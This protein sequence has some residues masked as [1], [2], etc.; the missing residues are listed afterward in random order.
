MRKS[1]VG[2]MLVAA[3]IMLAA[4]AS[5]ARALV[6][7]PPPSPVRAA[8]A[9]CIVI[10]RVVALEPQDVEAPPAAN[11]NAKMTYR[12][13]VIAVNESLKG[14]QG[15]NTLRLAFIPP[16]QG[17]QPRIRPGFRRPVL[18][19]NVGQDG[20]FF[21][22]KHFQGKFYLAPM[23][24][25]FVSSQT[26]NFDREVKETRLVIRW[27]DNPAQGL[28]SK[29]AD[30]R[31]MAAAL[32]IEKYRTVSG[33]IQKTEPIDAQESKQILTALLEA[34]WKQDGRLNPWNL[35]N[36]LGLTPQDGWTFPQGQNLKVED[37]HKAAKN[38]LRS[39][40]GT[41]RI[42]RLV[43]GPGGPIRRGGIPA[44]RSG[45]AVVLPAD[46]VPPPPPK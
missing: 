10:G 38:W 45:E 14:V 20:I 3:G 13:A 28:K 1:F 33:P 27:G 30:E 6:I 15:Q 5:P 9:E 29:N 41:Y 26:P 39:H 2:G 22:T 16:P 25:D 31:F 42:Q 37:F 44:I 21:L 17:N 18:N 35:F 36:R 40:V 34:D 12:I 23:Y 8:K 32:L 7:A 46:A 4:N 19:L 24:Y 43:S 11:V